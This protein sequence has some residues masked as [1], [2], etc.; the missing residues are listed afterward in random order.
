MRKPFTLIAALLLL[1][2]AAVNAY[3]AY[4]GMN[5]ELGD[6]V[7]PMWATWGT[8]AIAGIVGLMTLLELKK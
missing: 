8:A 5:A 7:I 4:A 3:R 1:L 6:H 2:V